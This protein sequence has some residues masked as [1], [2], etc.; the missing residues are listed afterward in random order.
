[1]VLHLSGII[2]SI[3]KT[4]SS[5]SK[6]KKKR[7]GFEH[8]VFVDKN[9]QIICIVIAL[10]LLEENLISKNEVTRENVKRKI[11]FS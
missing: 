9:T 10:L 3:S 7:T 6:Q 11:L 8:F 1:M 5:D 4:S 2:F